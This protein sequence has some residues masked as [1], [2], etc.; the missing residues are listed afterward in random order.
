MH[1]SCVSI[2]RGND[3]MTLQA[4]AVRAASYTAASENTLLTSPMPT[5]SRTVALNFENTWN[6]AVTCE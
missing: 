5:F 4:P 6:S 2:P 3:W 1:S